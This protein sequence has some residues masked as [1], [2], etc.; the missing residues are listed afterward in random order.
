MTAPPNKTD[1]PITGRGCA[2]IVGVSLLLWFVV[3]FLFFEGM[4]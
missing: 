2:T 1:I 4:S 3:A